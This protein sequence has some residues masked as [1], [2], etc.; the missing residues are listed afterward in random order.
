[1]LCICTCTHMYTFIYTCTYIDRYTYIDM[2]DCIYI[3]VHGYLGMS[4]H[5]HAYMCNACIYI[6]IYIYTYTL[7]M[8]MRTHTCMYLQAW[9][10]LAYICMSRHTHADIQT[11]THTHT[12]TRKHART[13]ARTHA[14]ARA[15]T[16]TH[17]HEYT[18]TRISA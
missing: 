17:L 2:C 9:T 6:Y 1:M 12:H 10:R 14:R 16:R 15:H 5:M 7:H 3:A 11:H 8:H 18:L 13:H 4:A